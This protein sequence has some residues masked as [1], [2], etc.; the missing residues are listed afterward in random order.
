MERCNDGK[1]SWPLCCACIFPKGVDLRLWCSEEPDFKHEEPQECELTQHPAAVF[2]RCLLIISVHVKSGLGKRPQDSYPRA[3]AFSSMSFLSCS[4]TP[5]CISDSLFWGAYFCNNLEFQQAP[6][7]SSGWTTALR[8]RQGLRCPADYQHVCV[9]AA[10]KT[11]NKYNWELS[12]AHSL[13][14][15]IIMTS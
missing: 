4:F 12:G 9:T 3:N 1:K 11:E 7:H 10:S 2:L 6:F 13:G 8:F 15:C 14:V 5:V